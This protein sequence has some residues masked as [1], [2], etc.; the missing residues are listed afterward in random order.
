MEQKKYD[1]FVSYSRKDSDV[2]RPIIKP[3]EKEGYKVWID[4]YGIESREQFKNKIVDV[5]ENSKTILF[6]SSANSNASEWTAK[7]IGI[8]VDAKIPIIPIKL[9]TASYN[10]SVKF[11]LI[12]LDFADYATDKKKALEK[13][14][15]SIVSICGIPQNL[16]E[17]E[18]QEKELKK[19]QEKLQIRYDALQED[20]ADILNKKTKLLKEMQGLGMDI[21]I[22]LED[23]SAQSS[24][25]EELDRMKK[26]ITALKQQKVLQK[27]TSDS[28]MTHQEMYERGQKHYHNEEYTEAIKWYR[29]AVEHGNQHAV[30]WIGL[31]YQY[32]YGVNSN[33][34]EAVKWYRKAAE[35]GCSTSQ[36]CLGRMYQYGYGV[37]KNS[38][39]ALTW[40]R[41][42]AEQGNHLGQ[43]DLGTMYECGTG[44]E[45]NI[46][47]AIKWYRKSAE[48]GYKDAKKRLKELGA[49]N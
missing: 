6:F 8:A 1:I 7:E 12:N 4:I 33:D 47:E 20:L 19:K 39:E 48:Q 37:E 10:K 9:D 46:Y 15:I 21:S 28:S 32:G 18:K 22:F 43:Y 36:R 26:E 42:S 13:M 34:T 35:Q 5:I 31:M 45:K 49:N 29:K 27:D 40:Y 24:Y 11:D 30:F 3:L 17:K 14:H 25:I 38:S 44:V 41:K 2:V 16:K 23:S